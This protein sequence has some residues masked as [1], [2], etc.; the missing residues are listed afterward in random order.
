MPLPPESSSDIRDEVFEQITITDLKAENGFETLLAFLDRELQKDDISANYDKFNDFEEFRR[1]PDHSIHEYITKFDQLYN[2]IVKRKMNLPSSILAFKLLKCANLTTDEHMIVLTGM[3]YDKANTLHEQAK[4]Y[5]KK[6]K[7]DQAATKNSTNAAMKLDA[8]YL[9]EN[10]LLLAAG[11]IRKPSI[12]QQQHRNC[13]G[14]SNRFNNYNF[15][16]D[17]IHPQ[18]KINT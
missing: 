16:R 7:R 3:N 4:K 2:R 11:Y 1:S 6:Y 10:E 13:P 18:K 8:V 14:F 9:A 15:R 12:A 17:K 5:L